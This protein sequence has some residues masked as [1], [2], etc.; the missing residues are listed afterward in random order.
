[1]RVFERAR[2]QLPETLAWAA[3]S[4]LTAFGVGA[5]L[6]LASEGRTVFSDGIGRGA[7]IGEA[8]GCGMCGVLAGWIAAPFVR[9]PRVKRGVFVFFLAL[10]LVLFASDS[11]YRTLTGFPATGA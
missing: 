1:M 5:L 11:A 7:V 2:A 6:G 10:W 8:L 4:T 3:A 9:V